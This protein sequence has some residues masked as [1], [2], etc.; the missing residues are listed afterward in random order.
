MGIEHI[1]SLDGKPTDG[2]EIGGSF[3]DEKNVR[4]RKRDLIPDKSK[5]PAILWEEDKDVPIGELMTETQRQILKGIFK[6]DRSD[7]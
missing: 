2:S 1:H 7:S 5:I 4:E 3:F 6:R